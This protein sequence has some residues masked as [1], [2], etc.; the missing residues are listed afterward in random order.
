MALINV[1]SVFTDKE[2]ASN[3]RLDTF[4]SMVCVILLLV[5][6]VHS[7]PQQIPQPAKVEVRLANNEEKQ[8][9]APKPQDDVNTMKTVVKEK[10]TPED[11]QRQHQSKGDNDHEKPSVQIRSQR[12]SSLEEPFIEV[13]YDKSVNLANKQVKTPQTVDSD[14]GETKAKT[15]DGDSISNHENHIR[16]EEELLKSVLE[17]LAD[18]V[19]KY[20]HQSKEELSEEGDEAEKEKLHPPEPSP[21]PP[22]M[23]EEQKKGK[24]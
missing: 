1:I 14:R 4:T 9:Q 15:D 13:E 22:P 12:K 19:E 2:M 16:N 6:H 5:S 23:T 21:T 11:M 8:L 20:R 24:Q 17:D 3:K 18:T 7:Q 10:N